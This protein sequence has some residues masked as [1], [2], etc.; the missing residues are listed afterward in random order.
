MRRLP[1]L[2]AVRVFESAARHQNFTAAAAELGMTQAAVSYQIR[3]L[4]ERLGVPLF[5][6]AKGRVA[7]TDA[8]RRAA[9]LVS[10][11]FDN[12][13]DAFSA[14]LAEDSSVLAISTTSTFAS[15]WLAPR[16]GAF[17]I[18][19]PELAV[20]LHAEN[21]VLDF[22]RD[23][24]DVG[25]RS[26][27][28]AP[29]WPG[30]K[31]HFLYRLHST[32]LCSPEFAARHRITEPAD[33][34]NVQRLSPADD[35]WAY[36]FR[37]A[38]VAAPDSPPQSGIRFDTQALEGNAALAGAGVGMLTPM[39]WRT[40]LASG[41]LVQ[42]FPMI[43]FEGPCFW[44]VYQEYK[45]TQAKIVAFRDWLLEAMR[46]AAADEPPQVFVEPRFDQAA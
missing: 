22:A 40:E 29:D 2:S 1:P 37:L 4:E 21:R 38:G 27:S 26:A 41:R 45:R 14:I 39:Y 30:L 44:L 25:I 11:G 46:Q 32:P 9:P 6:R 12:I 43:S 36:W 8:G 42:L 18:E 31:M 13:A 23:E 7:L 20:R 3:L 5:S 33:L 15:N 17:Q 28:G 19:R 34:L 16:L 35:W 24:L 10:A